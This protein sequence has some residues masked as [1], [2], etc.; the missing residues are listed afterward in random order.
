MKITMKITMKMKR[1]PMPKT[2]AGIL[3]YRKTPTLPSSIQVLL[4]HLGGPFFKNKDNGSWTIPKGEVEPNEDPLATAQREVGE[5]LGHRPSAPFIALGVIKQK[6]GKTVHAWAA[7]SD[8]D[9]AA[10]RSNT[11]T[12]EWP[13]RSGKKQEFPEI[14]RAQW[15]DLETAKQKINPAQIPLLENL[16][17]ILSP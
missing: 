4:V 17:P 9:P 5:E 1:I 16:A 6:G 8:L 13:P 11:F 12:L 7:E 15:F 3:L 2:S 14:D 10:I